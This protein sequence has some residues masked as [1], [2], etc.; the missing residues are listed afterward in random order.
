[1]QPC[2]INLE[3]ILNLLIPLFFDAMHVRKT[4]SV[5]LRGLKM[6]RLGRIT[7]SVISQLALSVVKRSSRRSITLI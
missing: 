2:Q 1:M 5:S 6:N 4:S 7:L 3:I